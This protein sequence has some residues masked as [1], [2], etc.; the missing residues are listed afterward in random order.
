MI[1]LS[2][3]LII[4]ILLV[5]SGCCSVCPKSG[6]YW[7]NPP[8]PI[9]KNVEFEQKNEGLFLDKT[10]SANLLYNINEMQAYQKNLE[11][12]IATMKKYYDAK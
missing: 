2:K 9:S 3:I 10:S 8:Q 5:V 4:S 12:M 1:N 6:M 7:D 11:A